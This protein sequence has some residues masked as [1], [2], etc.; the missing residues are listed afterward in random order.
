MAIPADAQWTAQTTGPV[1]GAALDDLGTLPERDGHAFAGAQSPHGPAPR[2]IIDGTERR[3]RRPVETQ[4]E[5]A[6]ACS[7]GLTRRTTDGQEP[8]E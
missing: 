6:P 3:R 7:V 1:L 8:G 4:R 5:K 2:L